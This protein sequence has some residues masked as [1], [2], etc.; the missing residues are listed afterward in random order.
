MNQQ[1]FNDWIPIRPNRSAM[2]WA[3][4]VVLCFGMGNGAGAAR[5]AD[6]VD[7]NDVRRILSQNCFTCHGPDSK[8]RK[9]G[10][11][12]LRLDLPESAR[13][14][15][16]DGHH[17]IVPG[18]PE[19]SEMIRRITTADLDDKMPPPDSGKK[20][21]LQEIDLLK[22][23]IKQGGEY[24][25]HWSYMKPRRSALPKVT[26]AGWPR[27]AIDHFILARLDLEKLAHAPEAE[28]EIGR[29]HV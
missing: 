8:E 25:R 26:D 18:H 7:F 23:W 3:L 28:R 1:K 29:A 2:S 9:S 16:G 11:K 14:D 21:T 5:A 10:R 19:K 27:N 15:L 6:A 24:S 13:A 22:K 17:A 20:L 12:S 4:A